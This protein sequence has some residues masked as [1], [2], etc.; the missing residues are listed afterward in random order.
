MT[1]PRRGGLGGGKRGFM[2]T[3]ASRWGHPSVRDVGVDDEAPLRYIPLP[4]VT[5]RYQPLPAVTYRYLLLTIVTYRHLPLPT[6]TTRRSVYLLRGAARDGDFDFSHPD[7][8]E[9]EPDIALTQRWG[10]E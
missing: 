9:S 6:V 4:T 3:K 10:G 7:E 1:E 8:V 5:D 2:Q